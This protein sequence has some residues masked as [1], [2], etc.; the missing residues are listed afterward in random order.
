MTQL[1]AEHIV[2]GGV[3]EHKIRTYG[4]RHDRKTVAW[5]T[6]CNV[7]A[8]IGNA[9]PDGQAAGGMV[10]PISENL[11]IDR[12]RQFARDGL[13]SKVLPSK[14][15]SRPTWVDGWLAG[16]VDGM[17]LD[18]RPRLRGLGR[19]LFRGVSP[20]FAVGMDGMGAM[21]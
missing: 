19:H 12:N 10:R 11:K 9:A 8:D 7:R 21:G 17:V 18:P 13:R 15:R 2:T 4:G 1:A 6:G 5:Q 20:S 16:L 3:E 14:L